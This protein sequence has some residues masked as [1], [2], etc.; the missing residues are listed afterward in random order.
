MALCKN[1]FVLLQI[2]NNTI[3]KHDISIVTENQVLSI[4]MWWGK[5]IKTL[6]FTQI[7]K[8]MT[9][10]YFE[11]RTKS[12][13]TAESVDLAL[14]CGHEW[15]IFLLL[16]IYRMSDTN[17]TRKYRRIKKY[18]TKEWKNISQQTFSNENEIPSWILQELGRALVST[19]EFLDYLCTNIMLE[20]TLEKIKVAIWKKI[21]Y[22]M[23]NTPK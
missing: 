20:M 5:P 22:V 8:I 7:F 19:L 23:S 13:L 16:L 3:T 6:F 18:N 17:K 11:N 4:K 12:F 21:D 15:N 9:N 1:V 14:F 2:H 10:K